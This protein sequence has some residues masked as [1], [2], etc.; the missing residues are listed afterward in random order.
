MSSTTRK[1][2]SAVLLLWFWIAVGACPVHSL[3]PSHGAELILAPSD[4]EIPISPVAEVM[5]D[6]K[7]DISLQAA[8]SA[9]YLPL[10]SEFPSTD[11]CRGYWL[12]VNLTA[13]GLPPGGWVL[14]LSR[15]WAHADLYYDQGHATSELRTGTSLPPPER[16]VASNY[17]LLPLP[18]E[19]NRPTV[20]YL[21]LTGDTSRYGEARSVA[22][23][24]QRQDANEAV[25][26]D[27]LFRQGVYGGIILGLALYNLILFGAIGERAYLYYSLY[28]LTFGSVW[29][30]RT[31][32]FFQYLWPRHP[33]I[34]SESTF[35]FVVLAIIFG[36]LFV[37][38]FLATREQSKWVDR[39]LLAIIWFT[40]A[41]CV[42]RIS[43]DHVTSRLLLA[44]DG[45]ATT[46]FFAAV[47]VLFLLRGYRPAR[48]FLVAWTLQLIGNMLYIFAFIRFIPF[49]FVTYNAAQAGS[50]LE[51]I[52]LAFALADR[53]NLLKR[54]KEEKQLQYTRELQEQ[55]SQ[56]TQEL[57][58][59]VE[60]L[61][62]ASITDPLT[63]LSNRRHVDSVIQPWIAELQRTRIRN[64]P[65]VPTRSLA[66]CL[67]DLDHFKL[68]N[69]ELGHAVGDRVLQAAADTLRQNVR[70]TAILARWGG[71]EFLV[72]DHVTGPQ[73]D[74]LM[75]ERLRLS[76][77]NECQ[78]IFLEI[79]R[80]VSLSLGVVRY[81]FSVG[82]PDL[83]DWDHCLVLADH[84]LYRAKK[85]GRNRWQC[86][87]PNESALRNAIQAQ[88][89]DAVRLLVR[90][91]TEQAFE[92]GLI[93]LIEQVTSD[94]KAL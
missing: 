1:W 19:A 74:V 57:T 42:L 59:A 78:T 75:A 3:E 54:E 17:L 66:V 11:Q 79:G 5:C 27:V 35:Y 67:A 83:L 92:M 76:I 32:F 87:R 70:A 28:V 46:I 77:L 25:R 55:V 41:L 40:I 65:S 80:S 48:F 26:R 20:F 88:G 12:R 85:T 21:H 62:T 94:V 61:K 8:E 47:G 69:D 51:S 84:A 31:G 14:Q 24:I 4:R 43:G 39:S 72:L 93:G 73:E 64:V 9:V 68:I 81:P 2:G 23:V 6:P 13:T 22:G 63:G 45:L 18:L 33:S 58:T 15:G 90:T 29:V 52:L 10:R 36:T 50:G 89:I 91:Q 49:N 56:R 53:V 38:Q 44:L 30:A 16:A 60:N 86:Y 82:Y 71:E 37:R 7:G 34:E